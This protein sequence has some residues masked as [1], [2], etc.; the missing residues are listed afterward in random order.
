[1]EIFDLYRSLSIKTDSKIVLLVLDGLGGHPDPERGVSE[2]QAARIP[3]LDNLASESAC[4]LSTAIAPGITPGSGPSHLS[5]FGYDPLVYTVGRGVLSALGVDFDLRPRDVAARVNFCT[6]DDD[7]VVAD[8]RAGRISTDECAR[9]CKKLEG[10]ELPGAQAF[11]W[12]EMDYRAAFVLR[13]EGLSGAVSDSDPQR[14]GHKP[15]RVEPHDPPDG[16]EDAARKTADL[17]NRY[18]D[19]A[20][21]RLEGEHP[22][23]MILMRGFDEHTDFPA[24]QDIYKLDPACIATY[25]MYK[26]LSKLVGMKILATGM[27]I[28]DE[29]ETLKEHWDRH[30]FFYFHIKKTDSMGED[31]NFDGK[32]KILEKADALIPKLREMGPDVLAVTGDHSTP[33]VLK[34]HSWHPIPFTI[35]SSYCQPDTVKQLD[36]PSCAQGSLNGMRHVDIMPMLMAN[37]LKFIKFGA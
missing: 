27:E 37:A 15:R 5:L 9:L 7:G 3:N 22:A 19:E 12:P 25:P 28:E 18:I 21:K 20:R 1:M 8:R 10:I 35:W 11:L 4:G 31:G 6:V 32:V 13:G 36:E 23:N 16:R 34:A 24:M 14:T 33:C 17:V 29:L 30:D 26:G 2:L